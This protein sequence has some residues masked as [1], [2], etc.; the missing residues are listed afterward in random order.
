M[1]RTKKTLLNFITDIV[2]M[3]LI[4]I[5]G[6]FKIRLFVNYLGED[7][8]GAYQLFAQIFMYLTLAEAGFGTAILYKLY[9]PA[10]D[11]DTKKINEL[12][13]GCRSIFNIIAIVIF[14]LGVVVSFG[15]N[16]FIK[17]LVLDYSYI[18]IA[19][20]INLAANVLNYFFISYSI[21]YNINQRKYKTNMVTQ[22]FIM[23]KSLGEIVLL[24][25]GGNLIAI[26]MLGFAT[27]LFIQIVIRVIAKRDYPEL[28]LHLEEKDYS[29]KK[30]VRHILPLKITSLI[31][32]NI[33]IVVISSFL[34]LAHVAIYAAYNYIINSLRNIIQKFSDASLASIGNLTVSEDKDDY[35]FFREFNSFLFF[36]AAVVCIPLYFLLNPFIQLWVGETMLVNDITVLFFVL[37]LHTT[38]VRVPIGSFITVYGLFKQTKK[39]AYIETVVNLG[40]TL[41]AVQ[42]YGILGVLAATTLGYLVSDIFRTKPLYN[43]KFNRRVILYYLEYLKYTAL[44]M[45]SIVIL[46]LCFSIVD[47]QISNLLIWFVIGVITFI[48][49]ALFMFVLFKFFVK[50]FN[51]QQRMRAIFSK[52]KKR[53]A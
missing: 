21:I 1:M 34:G 49:N 10:K 43:Q 32:N 50:E 38:I 5:I 4:A 48:V 8:L 18:Q 24:L 30:E 2:P 52:M 35:K 26:T 53:R 22:G 36:T 39:A 13:S 27:N 33:D 7:T 44:M 42:Y 46:Y 45:I 17:D 31:G 51:L 28:N 25:L 37:I 47:V 41:I 6:F 11:N 40:V 14:S 3:I 20:L 16:I 19:F 9:K 15:L 12:L 23:F 29:I